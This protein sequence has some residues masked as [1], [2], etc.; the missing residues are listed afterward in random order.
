MF[1]G[2]KNTQWERVWEWTKNCETSQQ[3]MGEK[4]NTL[5]VN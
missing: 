3:V 2:R 1:I 4:Y 5:K